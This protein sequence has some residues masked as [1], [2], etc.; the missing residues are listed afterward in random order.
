M[1]KKQKHEG[2]LAWIDLETTGLDPSEHYILEAALVI[3]EP[4]LEPIDAVS[5]P[6]GYYKGVELDTIL[7]CMNDYVTEMHMANGLVEELLGGDGVAGISGAESQFIALMKKYGVTECTLPDGSPYRSPMCGST[8]S[9]DRS[10]LKRWMPNLEKCFSYRHVDVSSLTELVRR[11]C[12]A[13]EYQRED[14]GATHRALDDCLASIRIAR[15]YQPM[16]RLW[17]GER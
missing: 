11:W 16:F 9:F 3:T 6:V 8:V 13:H 5:L 14:G 10:F 2:R 1:S 17:G 4:D 12:P 7:E 15:H